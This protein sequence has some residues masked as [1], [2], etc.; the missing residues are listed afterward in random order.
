MNDSPS[1]AAADAEDVVIDAAFFDTILE[2]DLA[3]IVK[4]A[5][6]GQPLTKREREMMEEERA[7]RMKK[8][9]T[10]DFSLEGEGTSALERM[11]QAE[12]AAEWGFSVRTIK[13]WIAQ[14]KS[15]GDP[16]PL[17]KPA[18]M[19]AW[20][21]RIH[22]PRQAPDKLRAAA[23][24]IV[25]GEKAKA[26]EN[27]PPVAAPAE[28]IEIAEHEKGMLAMLNRYRDAEASLHARYMAAVATGDESK[29]G[30][31][32]SEWSK[33]GEKLRQQEKM[34]PKA[35]EEMGIYVRKDHVQRELE[36]IHSA[37]IK[38]FRQGLRMARPRL[39]G[40]Q[41]SD[42]WSR[43]T[44]EVVNEVCAMLTD[45]DFREPLELEVA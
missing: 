14:G 22:A 43:I 29:S 33:M 25:A 21:A 39:K 5:N 3:N 28:Q 42:E 38:A 9:P 13:G 6:A 2:Q 10:C 23:Q 37:I 15:A 7:K 24:R 18:E 12:L 16:A 19:P 45:S 44:D 17:T 31:Y 4:K 41:T 34:A 30:F 20:F 26:A 1:P 27:P 32:M 35:L 40:S 11:T 36:P 8:P